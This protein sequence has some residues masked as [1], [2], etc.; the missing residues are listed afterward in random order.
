MPER[1][2]IRAALGW[3]QSLQG[4]LPARVKRLQAQ[5]DELLARPNDGELVRRLTAAVHALRSYQHGNASPELAKSIAGDGERLL[6]SRERF[7][8]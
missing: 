7:V 8:P 5:V 4:K 3:P 1:I 2:P 6:A